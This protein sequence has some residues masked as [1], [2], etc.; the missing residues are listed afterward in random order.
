MRV[1]VKHPSIKILFEKE[2]ENFQMEYFRIISIARECDRCHVMSVKNGE[3]WESNGNNGSQQG[4]G[5][6]PSFFFF[7]N[8]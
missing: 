1:S 8:M 6:V 4:S 2:S 5:G 3:C 7:L